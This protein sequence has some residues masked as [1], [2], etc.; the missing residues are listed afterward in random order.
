MAVSNRL[1]FE[2]FRRDGFRC[3]YCGVTAQEVALTIDHVTPVALG[4]NDHPN[5]LT[6][7]CEPCNSGKSSTLVSSPLLN[8]TPQGAEEE[9]A[10]PFHEALLAIWVNTSAGDI[11]NEEGRAFEASIDRALESDREEFHSWAEAANYCAQIGIN[12]I[13]AGHADMTRA[14]IVRRWMSCWHGATGEHPGEEKTE[15]VSNQ[16][17]TLLRAGEYN[18][19]R[20]EIAAI[21]AGSNRSTRFH[22]LLGPEELNASGHEAGISQTLEAWTVAFH[23]AASRWPTDDECE[24]L[25]DA[26]NDLPRTRMTWADVVG[27]AAAAATYQSTNV[28][29]CFTPLGNVFAAAALIPDP[30]A[31][32]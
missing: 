20:I 26:L 23:A 9:A 28:L 12:D 25:W 13:E 7:A 31:A 8:K 3:T 10:D 1:R 14:R 15:L 18:R 19:T 32:P 4:G 11:T 21:R 2:I 29:A 5:N 6:T 30:M 22:F 17:E 24:P 27:A 16:V